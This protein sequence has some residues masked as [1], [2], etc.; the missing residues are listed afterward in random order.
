MKR[1]RLPQPSK[2]DP[3]KISALTLNYLKR[4]L[5]GGNIMLTHRFPMIGA[6][7]YPA[8][9]RAVGP[10][11]ADTYDEWLKLF[12]DRVNEARRGGDTVAQIEVHFDEFFGFCSATGRATN[13]NSLLE[14][15]IEKSLA[16][17]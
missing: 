8:F 4:G 6:Q 9:R 14:F 16:Q 11:L 7:D 10:D 12:A 3:A 15:A 13:L 2:I 5:N 17:E 1:C